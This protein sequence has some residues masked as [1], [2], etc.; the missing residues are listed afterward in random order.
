MIADATMIPIASDIVLPPIINQFVCSFCALL[1]G[2][3]FL[4]DN[5]LTLFWDNVK[6]E[7]CISGISKANGRRML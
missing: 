7:F 6:W 1:F 2:A 5:K 3:L 4:S